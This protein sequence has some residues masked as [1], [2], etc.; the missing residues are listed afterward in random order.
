MKFCPVCGKE[1]KEW[2]KFCPYCGHALEGYANQSDANSTIQRQVSEDDLRVFIG[3]NSDYYLQKFKKF[4]IGATDVFA[5]TWNWSAFWGGFGWMLYRKMYM[6]AIIAFVLTLIPHIGLIAWIT[7]GAISNYFYYN[8]TKSKI[9]EI[10]HLHPANVISNELR[11]VGGTNRW[12]P[13]TAVIITIV[14]CISFLLMT[15]FFMIPLNIFN[16]FSEPLQYI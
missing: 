7:T 1:I 14:L 5:L 4:N 3:N 11:Q 6:W 15:F 13:L 16:I 2:G 9:L 8:H 12:V 10:K